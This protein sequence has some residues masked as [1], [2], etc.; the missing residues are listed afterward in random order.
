MNYEPNSTGGLS[1]ADPA[2][3]P[4][5]P[6]IR[7]RLTRSKIERTN[8]FAQAGARYR[9]MP[10]WEREDLVANMI[11]LL[12]QCERQIQE[13]M[14]GL[15]AQCDPAYGARVADGLGIPSPVTAATA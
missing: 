15:F 14:V 4:Y 5:E 1:E 10:D 3:P 12:G 13:R 2:G 6:E 7:G 11:A 8:D 9:T